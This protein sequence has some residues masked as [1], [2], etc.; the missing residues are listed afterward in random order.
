MKKRVLTTILVLALT[1][2]SAIGIFVTWR[3]VCPEDTFDGVRVVRAIDSDDGYTTIYKPS[4]RAL[5]ILD[6]TDPQIKPYLNDYVEHFGG[7][8]EDTIVFLE[9]FVEALEPDLVIITGDLVHTMAFSNLTHWDAYCEMFE[10]HQVYWA[11]TFGN[12]DSETQYVV[13]GTDENSFFGQ[14]TKE[15]TVEYLSRYEYC[16]ME[17]GDAEEGGGVGNYFINVRDSESEELIYTLC[18]MDCVSD[19]ENGAYYRK[20]TP[21]QVAWYER[22]INAISDLAYGE[23]RGNEEVV[24]SM[25]F[26]HVAVP[27]VF[28]AFELAWNDGNPTEDYYYGMLLEGNAKNKDYR[29]CTLFDKVTELGSTTAIFFGHHHDNGFR[30]KY[31]GVDLVYGQHSGLAH[32]Y[33]IDKD[34]NKNVDMSDIFTYGDE[35]GAVEISIESQDSYTIERKLAVNTIEYDDIRI[36]Y[37]ELADELLKNGY[38]LTGVPEDEEYSNAA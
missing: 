26:T 6:F 33:R 4:D 1:A 5:K 28:E 13:E 22:H 38:K 27:E 17:E 7:S 18:M 25:I 10:E 8:N 31:K 36:D 12:H 29:T 14:A 34:D 35:R 19:F 9:R 21:E 32:Y 3:E 37:E 2:V 23:D 16:L 11:P 30:V 15:K 24:K 20:K